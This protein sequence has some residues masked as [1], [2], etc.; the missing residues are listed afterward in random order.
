L[1]LPSA[2]TAAK[3]LAHERF[4]HCRS[5][6][7]RSPG[8]ETAF[9][10][11]TESGARQRP[12]RRS[13]SALSAPWKLDKTSAQYGVIGQDA[14]AGMARHR[15]CG[16][17]RAGIL[18]PG[19]FRH[20]RRQRGRPGR[21]SLGGRRET[22]TP[23]CYLTIGTGIGG[24]RPGRRC[25]DSR[26]MHPEVGHIYPRRHPSGPSVRR[27]VVRFHGDWPGRGCRGSGHHRP[28]R[29]RRWSGS[30]N[31]IRSGKSRPTILGQ[32]CA[33]LGHDR[34]AATNRHGRR[35]H[36]SGGACCPSFVLA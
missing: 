13:A 26:L 22:S 24:W 14:E 15:Y 36:E 1:S 20:R 30:M 34:I 23:S 5:R 10:R 18:L 6:P 19:R 2:T 28:P 7:R 33:Q 9:L 31:R 29:V 4:P 32:L 11:Q 27:R 25:A 35:R 17:S 8:H 3:I 21:A 12:R 16:H